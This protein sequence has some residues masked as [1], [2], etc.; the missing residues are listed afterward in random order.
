MLTQITVHEER[1]AEYLEK[2]AVMEEELK[3]VPACFH[4]T[5]NFEFILIF[6]TT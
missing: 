1:I 3:K 6:K 5:T 2:I 4:I